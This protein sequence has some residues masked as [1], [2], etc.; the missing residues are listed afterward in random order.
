M[1]SLY[2]TVTFE[3]D[4][5]VRYRIHE[6]GTEVCE[7]WLAGITNLPA[8]S[9]KAR[10]D[11]LQMRFAK[12]FECFGNDPRMSDMANEFKHHLKT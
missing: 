2:I 8:S 5:G 6:Q 7:E 10:L 3:D 9:H 11:A 12:V 4:A 1:A